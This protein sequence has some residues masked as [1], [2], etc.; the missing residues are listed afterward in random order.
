MDNYK[1]YIYRV[2]NDKGRL[3]DYSGNFRTKEEALTWYSKNGVWLEQ[4]FNRELILV[5]STKQINLF[6]NIE[7]YVSST[8]FNR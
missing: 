5:K 8:L 1:P 7:D 4:H 6:T 2:E 3:E